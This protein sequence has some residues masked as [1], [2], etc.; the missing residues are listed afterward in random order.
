M[1][2][3]SAKRGADGLATRQ[4]LTLKGARFIDGEG[5][6]EIDVTPPADAPAVPDNAAYEAKIAELE[7]ALAAKD[8]ELAAKVIEL[9]AAKAEN[10]D[11]LKSVPGTEEPI[12][13]TT[14]DTEEADD[15]DDFFQPK[16]G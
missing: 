15:I 6:G 7:A 3:T 16:E 11:L 2:I 10:Y 8:S 4:L 13:E 12:T 1:L 14:I 9:A 5:E